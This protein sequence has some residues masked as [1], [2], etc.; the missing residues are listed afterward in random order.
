[1]PVIE[2]YKD[3]LNE[4]YPNR[5]Y[6]EIK[7]M[8]P[9]IGLDI[10]SDDGNTI[11]VE[12]SPNR[13]DFSTDY[14]IIRA[15]RGL[16]GDQLGRPEHKL[17]SSGVNF[18]VDKTIQN[19]R[20]HIAGFVVEQ[21]NLDDELIKQLISMQE[22]L[23]H[24]IGRERKKVAIG[25]HDLSAIK[26]PLQYTAVDLNYR[27]VPLGAS[28]MMEISS[29]LKETRQGVTYGH[30]LAGFERAPAL[31]DDL[32]TT[33]S[34]P[35]II[36]G[37]ATAITTRTSRLLVDI[38]GTDLN[39]IKYT[40]SIIAEALWDAGGTVKASTVSYSP[41]QR[42]TYPDI[43]GRAI[44]FDYRYARNILG[45][46]ISLEEV[47]LALR[48]CR[49]DAK[50][51]GSNLKVV[52]PNYRTDIIHP[53]DIV[54][55]I[56]YGYGYFNI[57]P[58][59]DFPYN[60]GGASSAGRFEDKI[61]GIMVGLGFSEIITP[62]LTSKAILV[63]KMGRNVKLRCAE[64]SK[65]VEHACLRDSLLPGALSVIALNSDEQN[66][67]TLF[68]L[69]PVINKKEETA[70]VAVIKFGGFSKIKSNL[71]ALLNCLDVDPS[72]D[73]SSIPYMLRGGIIKNGGLALGEIGEVSPQVLENFGIG[74]PIAYF[75]LKVDSI[76]T[77][78]SL[79]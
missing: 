65:S 23:H 4:L 57:K 26:P 48:K 31:I 62:I 63:D 56:A 68:E 18:V 78:E 58:D 67:Q 13:P 50:K 11:R 29:V 39:T 25:Y 71:M 22:D 21:L 37:A 19:L 64:F 75:E 52:V 41:T 79:C 8:L 54:E 6:E 7:G 73:K 33:L 40:A 53:I 44:D 74:S 49:N 77:N 76:R 9:F 15:L 30:L 20:P 66:P 46:D 60:T 2:L 72:F 43:D 69:G 45:I 17:I 10:E 59:F 24:G 61:R 70:L 32:G 1:M 14:G 5:K 47:I 35:P 27:F 38:T 36:N 3:R 51:R 16:F 55:E 34:I 12:Y 42:L 28:S